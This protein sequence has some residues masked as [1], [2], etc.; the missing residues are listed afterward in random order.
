M[1]TIEL[2]HIL[3]SEINK[4][5]DDNLLSEVSNFIESY[6]ESDLFRL[7]DGHKIA[8]D[9]AIEQIEKGEYLSHEEANIEIAEWLNK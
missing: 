4:T 2:N 9:E 6:K 5:D 3:I 7:S 8:I 1:T